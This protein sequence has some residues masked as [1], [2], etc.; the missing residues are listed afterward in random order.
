[1]ASSDPP[2]TPP[3]TTGIQTSPETP[4]NPSITT[5]PPAKKRPTFSVERF[6]RLRVSLDAV[7]V[8][9]VL[10]FAFL[11]ASFPVTNS[12]FFRQIATGRLL[13]QGDYHFG[14]DPFTYGSAGAYWVNHS[15][16]FGL[17]VYALYQIPTVGGAAVV[18]F[19]ALLVMALAEI[20]L[21]VSRRVGQS[22]WIPAACTA[23]ALL[24]ISPRATLQPVCLSFL[25][26][27]LTL[28][29]LIAGGRRAA[30][31]GK[32]LW[33]LIPPLFALWVNCDEWFFV[34][35]LVVALYLAG[36]F[37]QQRFPLAGEEPQSD[38]RRELGSL[39]LVLVIG[40]LACLVNPHHIY[41]FTLPAE[42]GLSPA[43]SLLRND[44]QFRVLFL[45]PITK[46]YYPPYV[47]LSVAGMAYLPLLLLGAVSFVLA[48]GRVP[49]WRLS[50][51]LGFA[52]L[53]LYNARCIP[54]F[55]IVAGPITALNWL[56]YAAY[57]LGPAP[58]LTRSWR[59]WSLGGR[60]LTIVVALV[61][62]AATVPG[63]LQAR[64]HE[65]HRVGWRVEVDPSLEQA[66]RQ[67]KSWRDAGQ[68]PA[69]ARWFN[70]RMEV[71]N[72]LAWFAPGE[73]A[74]L[75]QRVTQFPKM[76][77]D[78]LDVRDSL[79]RM[80]PHED[81]DSAADSPSAKKNWQTILHEQRPH[82]WIAD[83][84]NLL[85]GAFMSRLMMF[86]FPATWD[87][88]YLHGR[89]VIFA[90][91]DPQAS[92]GPGPT[93]A[94]LDLRRVAF[95]PEAEQAPP[96]GPEV[97]AEPR[98][99]WRTWWQ[100]PPPAALDKETARLHDTR[101]IALR[102]RFIHDNSRA[103]EAVV[104]ATIVGNGLP[105]GPI[106][107]ILLAQSLSWSRTYDELFPAGALQA[108]RPPREQ[109]TVALMAHRAFLASQDS[110]P[111]DSLYLEVRAVR[112]ALLTN[113][114]DAEIYLMLAQAYSRLNQATRAG[115]LEQPV[116]ILKDIRRTQFLAALQN[117]IRCGPNPRTAAEA[118]AQ[119]FND[120]AQ[121]NFLDVAVHH[122]RE[123][124]NNLRL[125]GPMPSESPTQFGQLLD[126]V[127]RNLTNYEA[128]LEKQRNDYEV[129]SANRPLLQKAQVALQNG[130]AEKA[131]SILEQA[132]V[133]EFNA[134]QGVSGAR[135]MMG[136]FLDLGRLDQARVLLV[137][138]PATM[139]GKP[140]APHYLELHLRLA[141]ARGDY[142][143]ADQHLAD[144]LN[145][146]WQDPSGKVPRVE[147]ATQIGLLVARALLGDSQYFA[148]GVQAP[149]AGRLMPPHF[150]RGRWRLEAI[151]TAL[152]LG[153]Q[154]VEWYLTRGWLALEAGR[155]EEARKHFQM[156]LDWVASDDYWV[157]EVDRL[158]A[159]LTQ[160]E[161]QQLFELGPRQDAARQ[162]ARHYLRLLDAEQR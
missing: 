82:F 54:F 147:T 142:A 51:W 113:P 109:E 158:R 124:F 138:E 49:W 134:V 143:E 56:D 128:Q 116:Q 21:R 95:G 93:P 34:G 48:F 2:P 121:R 61:L 115:F 139:A 63:W 5:L 42:F 101:F 96:R 1:M 100:P 131:L 154:R 59:W 132:D 57:R 73:R 98:E 127:S 157:P 17:L 153:H 47:G 117:C 83:S 148:S 129:R 55:A 76:A 125:A 130:L 126:Q 77:E 150:W 35:P 69:E 6:T 16:L 31:G 67:I 38:R 81:A 162:L 91:K 60:A 86:A 53:S 87:L 133:N 88:C 140:V 12:D 151:E 7:L 146:A 22:L 30:D 36:E 27:G 79:E 32:Q 19:K 65:T 80:M 46:Y 144:A 120:F 94:S 62:V 20:L 37:F 110:G 50:V 64:P 14:V 15:W 41:A 108:A 84:T 72:Y 68:L 18:V 152:F 8:L 78:Y 10:V 90:R 161:I 13:A 118:H 29:L 74:F 105:A 71:A 103:W 112:R 159:F 99:E 44:V 141:A 58:R 97:V 85:A 149:S 39:A 119:L 156:V 145:N 45:S 122:L 4:A 136:L 23:L 3:A 92:D 137:P 11:L 75:D 135:V 33:W 26:L 114:D 106:P 28:W 89:I 66:A 25:F 9:V 43:A 102:Q 160:Q 123:R 111:T 24:T 52:L 104:A 107:N 155:A 70:L 40:L